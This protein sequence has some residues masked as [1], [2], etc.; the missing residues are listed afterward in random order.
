VLI[1]RR[2]SA[3]EGHPEARVRRAALDRGIAQSNNDQTAQAKGTQDNGFTSS[4]VATLCGPQIQIACTCE[5]RF[6]RESIWIV[7]TTAGIR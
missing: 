4:S 6:S 5:I 3:F 7:T 2:G 1:C